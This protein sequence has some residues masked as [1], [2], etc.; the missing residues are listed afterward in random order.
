M[1]PG[2]VAVTS[3]CN[4][5]Q[6]SDVTRGRRPLE[7]PSMSKVRT[8]TAKEPIQ[9]RAI[10]NVRIAIRRSARMLGLRTSRIPR[11]SL[12]VGVSLTFGLRHEIASA[13]KHLSARTCS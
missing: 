7:M 2:V 8:D 5:N 13:G 12:P 3:E 9:L 4:S 6:S 1:V 11:G 10:C